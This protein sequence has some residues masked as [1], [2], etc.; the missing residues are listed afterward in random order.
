MRFSIS[1]F[2]KGELRTMQILVN[3][4]RINY[5]QILVNN[6]SQNKISVSNKKNQAYDKKNQGYSSTCSK[7]LCFQVQFK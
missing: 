6:Q 4:Q 5:L 7:K 3:Q 1:T 2:S